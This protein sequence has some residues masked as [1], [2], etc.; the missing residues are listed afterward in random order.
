[1]TFILKRQILWT[2]PYP[3]IQWTFVI[4]GATLSGS[5]LV[6]SLWP[7]LSAS[8]RGIAVAVIGVIIA[9]HFLLAAGLQL[10]FFNYSH[11]ITA[12]IGNQGVSP[13]HKVSIEPHPMDKVTEL[14][15]MNLVLEEVPSG[16]SAL[17]STNTQKS[18]TNESPLQS[19]TIS[20]T[21][22]KE[23]AKETANSLKTSAI[24]TIGKTT[25][26]KEAIA[27]QSVTENITKLVESTQLST[28]LEETTR[29]R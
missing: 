7:P 26:E 19:E 11:N 9:L 15:G 3:W 10:Y 4:I 14:H 23:E 28:K 25:N 12:G 27:N 18:L 1:M 29:S 21:I 8:Q 22:A 17:E 2:I 24:P 6:L 16:I 20:T 5:V 13:A